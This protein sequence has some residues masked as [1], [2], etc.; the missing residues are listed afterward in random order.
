MIFTTVRSAR[1]RPEI[2]RRGTQIPAEATRSTTTCFFYFLQRREEYCVEFN[3]HPGISR[4]LN[5][6]LP[7]ESIVIKLTNCNKPQ[8]PS[9]SPTGSNE[10]GGRDGYSASRR[11][12]GAA[13]ALAPA[14]Y[15][16]EHPACR[17]S[18][19]ARARCACAVCVRGV[20]A[21]QSRR[22]SAICARAL[23][24]QQGVSALHGCP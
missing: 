20:R 7:R 16:A 1:E 2:L 23:V 8:I 17:A 6:S 10:H 22:G 14:R 12:R 21:R 11:C 24:I 9:P 3:V 19:G 13:P 15:A 5:D 4:N 18:D